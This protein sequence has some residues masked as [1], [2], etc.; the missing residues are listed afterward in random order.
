MDK[1]YEFHQQREHKI[2]FIPFG[3]AFKMANVSL[4]LFESKMN[5]MNGYECKIHVRNTEQH[6]KGRVNYIVIN[7]LLMQKKI[8]HIEFFNYLKLD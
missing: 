3:I 1:K 7:Q 2:E 4:D 8:S 6:G 5:L